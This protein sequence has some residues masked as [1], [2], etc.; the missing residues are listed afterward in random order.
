MPGNLS[1]LE[2]LCSDGANLSFQVQISD[3]CD[4]DLSGA[5]FTLN[6]GAAPAVDA[7]ASD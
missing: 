4:A 2:P 5:T 7:A 6:G 1:F 3:D